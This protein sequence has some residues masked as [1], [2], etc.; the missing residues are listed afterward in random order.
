[1][2]DQAVR[3]MAIRLLTEI[4]I[5]LAPILLGMAVLLILLGFCLGSISTL[6][7]HRRVLKHLQSNL[8]KIMKGERPISR[9]DAGI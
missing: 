1:M 2:K 7:Y 9:K 6:N 5:E 8:E 3:D 4:G